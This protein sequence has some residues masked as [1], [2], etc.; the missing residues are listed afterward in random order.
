MPIEE[1]RQSFEV[2]FGG[3]TQQPGRGAVKADDF[4][5]HEQIARPGRL[6]AGEKPADAERPGVF[7]PAVVGAHRH[8]HLRPLG[9]H[10]QFGEQP[11]Q[12][13]IGAVV[14]HQERR[15]DAHGG[16]IA[17]VD[18]VG[19]G[20]TAQPAVGLIQRDPVT[21]G[22]HVSGGQTGDTAADHRHRAREWLLHNTYS[23][24]VAPRTAVLPH[25][26]G[27]IERNDIVLWPRSPSC[28]C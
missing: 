16:A 5:E 8:R 3:V 22:Q 9:D 13:R 19:V 21:S 7:Q 4:G 15:V 2:V 11:A 23:E 25:H 24:T 12:R 6:P 27:H 10:A 20:M 28:L 26:G 1:V 18:E 14:V 17:A